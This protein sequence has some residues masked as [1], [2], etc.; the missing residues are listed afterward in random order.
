[1]ELEE[2]M[3]YS[4]RCWR[5]LLAGKAEL[6]KQDQKDIY[7]LNSI[8]ETLTPLEIS[9]RKLEVALKSTTI[10]LKN[11]CEYDEYKTIKAKEEQAYLDTLKLREEILQLKLERN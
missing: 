3:N 6:T 9:I 2:A 5:K 8:H 10:S 4:T 7:H 1:M 11:S